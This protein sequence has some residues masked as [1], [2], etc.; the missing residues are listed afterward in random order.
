VRIA[1]RNIQQKRLR[2]PECPYDSVGT[3]VAWKRS[4]SNGGR[5]ATIAALNS[6]DA[7]GQ[8]CVA[9]TCS[10]KLAAPPLSLRPVIKSNQPDPDLTIRA[11]HQH[12]REYVQ[13]FDRQLTQPPRQPAYP[14]PPAPQTWHPC[15]PHCWRQRPCPTQPAPTLT[16]YT[17]ADDNGPGLYGCSAHCN[18]LK[19]RFCIAALPSYSAPRARRSAGR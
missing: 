4:L 6:H 7:D 5:A 14:C 12:V 9:T 16:K 10:D 18:T 17:H 3:K 13:A 19:L 8:P 11:H 15:Y 1:K 2:P